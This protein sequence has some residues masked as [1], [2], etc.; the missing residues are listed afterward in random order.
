MLSASRVVYIHRLV[1]KCFSVSA[2]A[3]IVRPRHTQN[4]A[5]NAVLTSRD[6]AFEAKNPSFSWLS[7]GKTKGL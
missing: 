1:G 4:Y 5:Q 6:G 7:T 2:N 3:A